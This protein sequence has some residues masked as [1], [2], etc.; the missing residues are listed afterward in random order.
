MTGTTMGEGERAEAARRRRV[1]ATVIASLLIGAVL[2][3]GTMA[4]KQD[5]GYL[6]PGWAVAFVAI[7][8]GALLLCWRACHRVDEVEIRRSTDAMAMGGVVYAIVYP[9]WYFLSR[10]RLV[11]EPDDKA[12]FMI[13]FAA[14]AITYFWKKYR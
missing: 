4:F 8:L 13:V 1:A 12:I 3:A 5:H 10:G 9:A 7:Y 11:I 14:C 2:I 6:A